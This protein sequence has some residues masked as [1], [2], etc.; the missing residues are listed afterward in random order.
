MSSPSS[1]ARSLETHLRLTGKNRRIHPRKR[2][3]FFFILLLDK[4]RK[5]T[6]LTQRSPISPLPRPRA[7]VI[8][9]AALPLSWGGFSPCRSGFEGCCRGMGCPAAISHAGAGW[10][11]LLPDEA[12][13]LR[14]P[15]QKNG[16]KRAGDR[17]GARRSPVVLFQKGWSK[18]QLS[19]GAADSI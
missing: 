5:V 17:G 10:A 3:S 18:E 2:I 12:H 1:P 11:V 14:C 9:T 8:P 16:R 15:N 6:Y 19:E 13:Y 4:D 7:A